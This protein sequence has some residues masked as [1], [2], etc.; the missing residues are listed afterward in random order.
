MYVI[1]VV[2]DPQHNKG[3]NNEQWKNDK[4]RRKNG[5]NTMVKMVKRNEPTTQGGIMDRLIIDAICTALFMIIVVSGILGYL[6]ICC[7][8]ITT[9]ILLMVSTLYWLITITDITI[10]QQ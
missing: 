6:V 2:D 9:M 10:D 3:G 1:I 5:I 4:W 8:I 7:Y